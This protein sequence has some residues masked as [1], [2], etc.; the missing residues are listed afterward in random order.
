MKH[1]SMALALCLSGTVATAHDYGFAGILSNGNSGEM[2]EL[3][4]SVGQPIAEGPITLESGKVYE[5]E[6]EADGS[7]ELA[8][9]GPD[10]FRAIWVNEVVI[11]G[12]EI[13]PY[14]LESVEFD[15]AG[16]M[17]IEFVAIKPGTYELK[18][19]GSTGDTQRVEITIK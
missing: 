5:L 19:P 8:L 3:T 17:E 12:L 9:T 18:I 13:R 7:G 16:E 1:I 4:L 2:P 15:E 10:F 14:G 11:N 6:I